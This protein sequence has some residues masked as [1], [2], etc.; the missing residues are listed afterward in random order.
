MADIG[1]N[2][3]VKFSV[4]VRDFWFISLLLKK[5]TTQFKYTVMYLEIT[6][7]WQTYQ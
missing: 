2:D 1:F 3:H 7:Q 5:E 6:G 4:N